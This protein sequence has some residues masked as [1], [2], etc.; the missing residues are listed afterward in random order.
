MKMEYTETNITAD[1]V[2]N[3]QNNLTAAV[4][5]Y[6]TAEY[7]LENARKLLIDYTE[8]IKNL[9]LALL[10]GENKIDESKERLDFQAKI[11]EKNIKLIMT[12]LLDKFPCGC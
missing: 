1:D 9:K 11:Y 7:Q 6:T 5:R 2:Q 3:L 4:S 8:E 12:A 10:R